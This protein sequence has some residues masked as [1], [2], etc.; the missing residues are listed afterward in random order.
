MLDPQD[1]LKIISGMADKGSDTGLIA[2]VYDRLSQGVEIPLDL[3]QRALGIIA[4]QKHLD[5]QIFE[6]DVRR[7]MLSITGTIDTRDVIAFF[8][9]RKEQKGQLYAVIQQME[10]DG[11]ITRTGNRHG[12]YRL[13]DRDPR[14]MNLSDPEQTPIK[15]ELPFLLH[16]LVTLFPK[17]IILV[18][19]EKDAGKTAFAMNVAYMN[20]ETWKVRY[21]N[22][23]MG[24][25]ELRGRLK[26]FGYP[27]K[28]WES[29]T[30]I[31]QAKNFEDNI[32]PDGLN[33]I[34]FLEVGSEAYTVTEDIRRAFDKL[35]NGI[36]L[37]V[38]QKRSYK[39]YAVGGE[40]TLE[41]ARLAINLE[42]KDGKNIARIT[43]A[44]NWTSTDSPKWKVCKY[45]VFSGGV[46]RM[47]EYWERPDKDISSP[48]K[49]PKREGFTRKTAKVYNLGK[50]D[51]D[52]FVK[53]EE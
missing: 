38:M 42:H 44:K 28:D 17:N 20:R 4:G 48:A 13:V 3:Q 12:V 21:F 18:S 39:E 30:W 45:S 33:I 16:D 27:M 22:S 35:R 49:P 46:M 25:E 51:D 40:G 19:G 50:A 11:I 43:V 9:A 31:E 15:I 6:K 8:E 29:I 10:A 32:D 34:D 1:I 7:F 2:E 14:I 47:D 5:K 36:L 37:I 24:L 23:E 53:E 52:V 41:K 26:K